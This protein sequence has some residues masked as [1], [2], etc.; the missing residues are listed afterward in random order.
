M[1]SLVTGRIIAL[2]IH[3]FPIR[4]FIRLLPE[5]VGPGVLTESAGNLQFAFAPA[6]ICPDLVTSL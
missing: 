2:H 6:A 3:T 5:F 1:Y 4:A